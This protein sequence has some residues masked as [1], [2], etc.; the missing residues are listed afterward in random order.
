MF[1]AANCGFR[2]KPHFF[3][4]YKLTVA[5]HFKKGKMH[6]IIILSQK[7]YVVNDNVATYIKY[8]TFR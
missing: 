3:F 6:R 7:K 8:N 1:S 5:N 4:F 2:F